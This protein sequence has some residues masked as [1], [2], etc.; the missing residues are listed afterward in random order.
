MQKC[1]LLFVRI[2]LSIILACEYYLFFFHFHETDSCQKATFCIVRPCL[3]VWFCVQKLVQNSSPRIFQVPRNTAG[4]T[5]KI[6]RSR[7]V[8]NL[9]I[10]I[11]IIDSSFH[12]KNKTEVR[13]H[14]QLFSFTS[15]TLLISAGKLALPPLN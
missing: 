13:L 4:M 15:P 11:K 2:G 7:L 10:R 6:N 3:E 14:P 12:N 1:A 8:F 5:C 9:Y